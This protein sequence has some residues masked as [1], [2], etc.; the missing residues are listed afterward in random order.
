MKKWLKMI[1]ASVEE[2][3]YNGYKGVVNGR[4]TDYFQNKPEI[5]IS[6]ISEKQYAKKYKYKGWAEKKIQ[7]I[8]DKTKDNVFVYCDDVYMYKFSIIEE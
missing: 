1:K 7:E 4:M 5:N 3:T 6:T 8:Y 2:T